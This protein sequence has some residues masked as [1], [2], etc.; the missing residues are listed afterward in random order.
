[1]K[2]FRTESDSLGEKKI[3]ISKI[4][5]AQTQRSLEN[6]KIGNEKMPI[7]VI[8]AFGYQKKAAAITNIKLGRLTKKVGNAIINACDQI[9]NLKLNNEFPLSVWQTGSGTQTNMNANEVISNYAIKKLGGKIGSKN[10][11]HPNDHVNL[12]QSS[13]DTFPTVMHISCNDLIE[14]KLIISLNNLINIL[15]I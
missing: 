14:N 9:I 3:D 1:M 12:S 15:K 8:I 2:E 10:P 7:E 4:W 13:N 11:V 5:G 6:F